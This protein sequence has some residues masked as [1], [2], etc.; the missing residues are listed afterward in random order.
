MP[1]F[2]PID[3][4][5]AITLAAS[6]RNFRAR[7][8]SSQAGQDFEQLIYDDLLAAHS[9]RYATGPDQFG[10]GLQLASRTGA[11]YEFDGVF[12]TDTTLYVVE[13]KHLARGSLTREH[14]GIFVQKLLDTV[15]GAD[16]DIARFTLKP[17]LVSG[18]PA[19]DIAAY[20]YAIA[21]GIL[22]VG[23]GR[24]TPFELGQ[25]LRLQQRNTQKAQHVAQDWLLLATH[26]WRPFNQM[27]SRTEPMPS[28]RFSLNA[29]YIYGAAQITR[30]MEIWDA[31]ERE[32]GLRQF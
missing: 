25:D 23:P 8:G 27:L 16:Q 12:G 13:A 3:T 15:L 22:L 18:Q 28:L 14:V 7:G 32:T 29:E 30:V 1:E 24:L 20:R 9:W 26:L 31:C 21:W 6:V 10:M 2:D 11:E 17:V 5:V 19:V 4:R